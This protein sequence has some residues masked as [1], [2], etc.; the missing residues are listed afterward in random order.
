L[1]SRSSALTPLDLFSPR[2]CQRRHISFLSGTVKKLGV[3]ID[4][5]VARV[6]DDADYVETGNSFNA[7]FVFAVLLKVYVWKI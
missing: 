1:P 3:S 5:T 7:G 4:E 6:E 2:L